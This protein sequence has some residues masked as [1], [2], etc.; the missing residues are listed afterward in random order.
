MAIKVDVKTEK[1]EERKNRSEQKED[2][3]KAWSEG[4]AS[5][6][7]VWEDSYLRLYKPWV[8]SAGKMFERSTQIVKDATPVEY[9]EFFDEWMNTYQ[10]TFGTFATWPTP[11]L[12]REALTKFLAGA[13]KSSKVFKS[14]IEE[15]EKDT[16]K[17]AEILQSPPDQSKYQQGYDMW[18]KSY[19]KMMDEMLSLPVM[20]SMSDT[21][22][23]YT[24]VPDIYSRTFVQVIKLWRD[25]YSRLYGP[26]T[27]AMR[28]LGVKAADISRGNASP[29][30]YKEFYTLWTNTYQ[31]MYQQYFQS[32]Q[33]SKESFESFSRAADLYLS[34]YKSWIEALEKMTE[35]TKELTKQSNDPAT[36]KEFYD[37]WL[38]M[39]EKAFNNFFENMPAMGPMKEMMEPVKIVARMYSDTL[40]NMSKTWSSWA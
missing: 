28:T 21:Y 7:R 9:K 24:G 26:L 1:A 29:E 25:S 34:T 6:S 8:E 23:K 15:L 39:Y 35:K 18:V 2:F 10:N 4:Y 27:D 36:Q 12:N 32:M 40:N 17:T 30:A 38:K 14:W 33:P 37:V 3:F 16:R 19:D 20:E 22:E 11:E 31:D 5:A 13:E